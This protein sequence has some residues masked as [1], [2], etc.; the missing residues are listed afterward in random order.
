MTKVSLAG[1]KVLVTLPVT[2]EEREVIS[3]LIDESGGSV[4]F[5]L[6]PDVVGSDVD[7]AAIVLGN[8]PAL[9]FHSQEALEWFQ[10][11][12]A[13]YDNYLAPGILAPKVRLSCAAGTYGQAVSEH[14]FAQLLCLMKKLHLYRD[15]QS[16]SLWHDEGFVDTPAGAEVLVI[17]AG[18]IGTKFAQ[19]LAS[20]GAKVTGVR[21]KVVEARAPYV[22]MAT[23]DELDELL[24]KADVVASVLPSTPDTRGLA[25]AEFF[26]KMKDGAYFVN[27]GRGDLVDSDALVDALKSGKLAGAAL[28]VTNPE[29]LPKEHALWKQPNA[30]I[31]PHIA[32]FWHLGAQTRETIAFCINN[33]RAYLNGES[34]ANEVER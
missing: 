6:E 5:V 14:M 34:L 26:Q 30:L 22:H 2:D 23:M 32:G 17:G 33:L 31:S 11:S 29:P 4:S 24:P 19:L 20:M 9:L 21:R 7:E 13:G 28:D 18:D 8:V 3:G 10:T 27:G 1:K 16:Q 15:N 25:N 12:S